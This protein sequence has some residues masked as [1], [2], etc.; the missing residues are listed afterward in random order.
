M[1]SKKVS[2]LKGN[3]VLA[4]A[5]LTEDY[6]TILPEGTILKAKYIQKLQELDV[7]KVYIV[8]EENDMAEEV[9]ILKSDMENHVREK[10]KDVL[11]RHTYHH[12]DE[13]AELC[14]AAD[15]VIGSIV[16]EEEVVE[17]VFDI[18]ER[19]AD[20]YEHSLSVC[21]LAV[22]IALK[23][24][25]PQETVHD[26]GVAC[27]LH[28]VGLRYLAIDYDNENLS[29]LSEGDMAE[30][31]KHPVY[32]YSA[33]K[34]EHWISD[35]SKNMIL[36][37]HERLDGSGFPLHAT[38]LSTPVEIINICDAFDEMICGIGQDKVKVHE[39]VEY[40]KTFRNVKFN[41][42]IVDIFLQFTAVYPV[43]TRVVTNEGETGVVIRQNK[44]FA[45]RPVLQ[46]HAE[47]NGKKPAKEK[48]ID[49]VK[50]HHVFID[51]VLE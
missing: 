16:Q 39:A 47:A 12:N 19:S 40:L 2:E 24:Q 1:R 29:S 37:H 17:R 31:K 15:N 14:D 6:I 26:I 44:E 35:T 42:A 36:Y 41:G 23:L 5:I 20:I 46:I 38:K 32:G 45:D 11:E 7:K 22:L 10:V 43:G 30:F 33:L 34:D 8:D 9:M 21:T 25:L 27:L 49:M 3:E 18:K 51:K 13:L 28:D 48:I 50:V 4:R